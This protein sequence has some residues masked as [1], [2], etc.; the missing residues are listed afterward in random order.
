M[1]AVNTE[2]EAIVREEARKAEGVFSNWGYD[3]VGRIQKNWEA[4]G[5]QTIQLPAA[6]ASRYVEDVVSVA[7]GI[8]AKNPQHKEDYQALLAAAKK[9]RK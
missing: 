3:E 8:V 5:G 7:A 1:N 9:H 2:N 6:E 4:N